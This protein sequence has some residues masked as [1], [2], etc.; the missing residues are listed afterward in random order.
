MTQ[1]DLLWEYQ[2]AD[3]EADNMAQSI[4]QSPKR[5][6]L[7][8]LR[9]YIREQQESLNTLEN[10]LHA[11]SDRMDVL[12]EAISLADDQLKDLQKRVQDEQP[13]SSQEIAQF[14]TQ[15][16]ELFNTLNDYD[17]EIRRVRKSAEN[18]DHRQRDIKLRAIRSKEEFDQL[19]IEY[20]QE[21][22]EKSEILE[23]LR[24]VAE[25]KKKDILP[26]YLARYTAIK[27]HST[28]P[29]AKLINGQCGGCNMGFPSSDLAAIRAGKQ[30]ECETCG[31][32]II[33]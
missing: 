20:D 1:L 3:T 25:Q 18:R 30:V 27:Q 11:M 28:P 19:R 24:A 17:Q 32:L 7:L 33:G 2:L 10:E 12:K 23:Q 14:I 31:R 6:K 26:E 5:Q 8:K 4:R 22:K 15:A 21:Y 13:G 9:D 16:D 29:M